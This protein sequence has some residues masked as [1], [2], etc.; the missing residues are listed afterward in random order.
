[1]EKIRISLIGLNF[2]RQHVR[3]LASMEDADAITPGIRGTCR[4]PELQR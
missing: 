4:Q 2:G 3:T 1:M